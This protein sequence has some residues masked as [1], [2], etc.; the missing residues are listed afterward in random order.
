MNAIETVIVRMPQGDV[1][2][3]KSD[4]HP[5]LGPIVD[6]VTGEAFMPEAAPAGA[7]CPHCGSVL[8]L[9]PELVAD[10]LDTF[11]PVPVTLAVAKIGKRW[12]VVDTT[13]AAV[14]SEG[15]ASEGYTSEADAWTAIMG[16]TK[17]E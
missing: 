11:V 13:G 3:N 16:L 6:P 4:W 10:A 2:V 14:A 17:T 15:I 12:Q 5:D 1:I 7:V 9:G 8:A